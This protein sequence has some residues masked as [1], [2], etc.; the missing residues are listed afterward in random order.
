MSDGLSVLE[1]AILGVVE[2]VTEFLPVS[3]TGHL[4]IT[5]RLLGLGLGADKAAVDTY[6][7]AIQ[8]GAIVAVLGIYRHRFLLMVEGVLGRSEE[9]RNSL[10]AVVLA[11]LPAAAIGFLAGDAIKEHL[12]APWPVVAAW[13]VGGV[14]ILWF[15][16]TF[17]TTPHHST[18]DRITPRTA[19]M[20]GAAQTLALWPGTSRS[21]VTILAALALGVALDAAV[22]FSF[23]LG[24]LTLGMA[25]AY[26]LLSD[27]AELVDTFGIA[28]P[29]L[30][31]VVAG[32]AAFVSVKAM[33]GWLQTRSLDVFG[34]Y[35]IAAAGTAA[36]LILTGVI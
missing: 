21:L 22:E 10:R 33:V 6:T 18:I 28:T 5:E 7:I 14:A 13:F 20:I 2:G 4:L 24:F 26:S 16:R 32:I 9:G 31:A 3:S 29:L 11:F 15:G 35:R 25:T 17:S 8:L 36:V 23:L 27:G 1:A 30:G 19:L 12:L 34:W